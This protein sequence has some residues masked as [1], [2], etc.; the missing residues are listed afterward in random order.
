M[1]KSFHTAKYLE[2]CIRKYIEVT[3]INDCLSQTK[4]VAVNAMK[5]VLEGTNYAGSLKA[6]LIL[7]HVIESLRWEAFMGNTDT[8]K[9]AGFLSNIKKL[10]ET[11]SKND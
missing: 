8:T 10:Q 4:V 9:Y 11:V 5:S 2:H 6:I 7:A 3:G 1:L